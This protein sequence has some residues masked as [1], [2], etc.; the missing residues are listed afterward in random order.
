MSPLLISLATVI[1]LGFVLW[2]ILAL[3]GWLISRYEGKSEGSSALPERS[4]LC[5]DLRPFE[6]LLVGFVAHSEELVSALRVL[7]TYDQP[8]SLTRIVHEVR[9]ARNG[10]TNAGVA[11]NITVASLCILYLAGLIRFKR[12]QFVTTRVGR[13]LSR[14]IQHD[15]IQENPRAL[16]PCP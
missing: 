13:E 15:M 7:V 5:R 1:V 4:R 3:A 2:G 6:D 9:I 16:T 12:G 11:A 8:L 14:R 10:S